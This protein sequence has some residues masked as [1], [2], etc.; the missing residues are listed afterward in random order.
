MTVIDLSR[1]ALSVLLLALAV[2]LVFP[3]GCAPTVALNMGSFPEAD[4][5]KVIVPGTTSR[6]EILDVFG[7]PDLDGVDREGLL[8]WTYTRVGIHVEK[9]RDAKITRFFSLV[10]S[11]RDDVVDSYTFDKKAGDGM[12]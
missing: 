11:F 5:V 9:A 2:T 12:Q 8:K 10:I 1:P 7:P 6:Q 3:A 4:P